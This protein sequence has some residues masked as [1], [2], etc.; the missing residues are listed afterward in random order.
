MKSMKVPGHNSIGTKI[1][2]L[3]QDVFAKNLSKLFN[4]SISQGV[5]PNAMNAM[6]AFYRQYQTS[7]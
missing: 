4:N 1:T 7:P 3:C 6:N 2:H 5:Y